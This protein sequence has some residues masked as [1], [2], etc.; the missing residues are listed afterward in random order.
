MKND[1][2]FL[3]PTASKSNPPKKEE[4]ALDE[5]LLSSLDVAYDKRQINI[6]NNCSHN[7]NVK[8]DSNNYNISYSSIRRIKQKSKQNYNEKL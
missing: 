5:H 8:M 1:K 7:R 4:K 2:D 3:K 6:L